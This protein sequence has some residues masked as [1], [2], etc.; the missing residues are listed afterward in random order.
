M[1]S[2]TS[3][4]GFHL[5]VAYWWKVGLL[6]HETDDN[7]SRNCKSTIFRS[8]RNIGGTRLELYLTT[9][10]KPHELMEAV[11]DAGLTVLQV[12]FMWGSIIEFLVIIYVFLSQPFYQ[13]HINK[14]L[15]IQDKFKLIDRILLLPFLKCTFFLFAIEVTITSN[16]IN[17]V[18]YWSIHNRLSAL[19][20]STDQSINQLMKKRKKRMILMRKNTWLQPILPSY[21]C[22]YRH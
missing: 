2:S 5:T 9:T 14:N 8:C 4:R 1:I 21:V 22:L 6:D 12:S 20:F 15:I 7:I 3:F 13:P 11:K 10:V 17:L 19:S 18:I 16:E